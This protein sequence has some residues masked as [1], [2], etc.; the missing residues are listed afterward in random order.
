[1]GYNELNQWAAFY[2]VD[3][4]MRKEMRSGKSPH[5]ALELV[6]MMVEIQEE[7]EAKRAERA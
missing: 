6:K 1:M 5:Q 3:G 2:E 4:L 7:A